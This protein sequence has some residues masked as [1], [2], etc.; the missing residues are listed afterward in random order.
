MHGRKRS[1]ASSGS[2]QLPAMVM[3]EPA[4]R[5]E[6]VDVVSMAVARRHRG[7]ARPRSSAPFASAARFTAMVVALLAIGV[8]SVVAG[9]SYGAVTVPVGTVWRVV[10]HHLGVAAAAGEPVQDQIVWDLRV[11]RALLGV[12]VGA[13]LAVAGTVIQAV[14]R[15]PL[16][17]PYLLGIVPGASVGAVLVIVAG[18]SSAAGL[19]IGGAAFVGAMVAFA[20]TF[21]LS[22]QGGRWPPSRLVLAGVAVGYLLSSVTFFLQTLATPNQVQRALFWSLGSLASAR[23]SDLA[24]PAVVVACSTA[25]LLLQGPRLNALVTGEEVAGSL[26]IDVARF[27]L[28]LMAIT[29][30]LTG[31][32]VAVAGGI[33]FVGLMIPHLVRL[34]V[35][36]DHR[37]VL[38]AGA[39]LGGVFLVAVDVV[40]RMAR[41]PVELPIGIVSAAIGAP[42]F[43][44]LLRSQ[45]RVVR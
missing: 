40:A 21:T 7:G 37:R 30:L 34:L 16:G 14:V 32:V 5:G 3:A 35:G 11:P 31:A 42:F 10:L 27:Q 26:G 25:W 29:S 44:W 2:S 8:A 45:S 19:S 38:L 9:V 43:L 1:A 20:A 36:A 33:G 28:Q 41:Q 13:G 22:R 39:L 4:R 15:N 12:V 23:W 17:D 6:G 24:L 18:S